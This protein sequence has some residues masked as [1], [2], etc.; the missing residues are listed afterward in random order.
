MQVP[1]GGLVLCRYV[2]FLRL[3][4]DLRVCLGEGEWRRRVA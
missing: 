4:V 2:I 1:V 3:Q